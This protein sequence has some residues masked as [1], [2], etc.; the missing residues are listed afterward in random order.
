MIANELLGKTL[1]A[2]IKS[3]KFGGPE[4]YFSFLQS[5]TRASKQEWKELIQLNEEAK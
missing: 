5:D 2:R 4:A 3:T 1:V